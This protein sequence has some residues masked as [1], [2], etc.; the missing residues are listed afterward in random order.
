[1]I[2]SQLALWN[3]YLTENIMNNSTQNDTNIDTL[4]YITST[5]GKIVVAVEL[6][7]F[8]TI[9]VIFLYWIRIRNPMISPIDYAS[10]RRQLNNRQLHGQLCHERQLPIF[11]QGYTK[12]KDEIVEP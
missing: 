5:T 11:I 1:M 2:I 6:L 12:H 10:Y 8:I 9:L 3:H 4:V 7:L